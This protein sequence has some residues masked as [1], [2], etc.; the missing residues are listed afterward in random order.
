MLTTSTENLAC[1]VSGWRWSPLDQK[2][3]KPSR[4]DNKHEK[5]RPAW[6]LALV[7]IRSKAA[8]T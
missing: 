3:P 1:L 7:A 2:L 8:Q 4:A 5:P 6:Y